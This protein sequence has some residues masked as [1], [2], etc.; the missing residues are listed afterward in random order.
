MFVAKGSVQGN[1]KVAAYIEKP[2]KVLLTSPDNIPPNGYIKKKN[3]SAIKNNSFC[4]QSE[5]ADKTKK[6]R[7]L[8]GNNNLYY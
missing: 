3:R 6:L 1:T 7:N 2:K 8:Y 4:V 5:K